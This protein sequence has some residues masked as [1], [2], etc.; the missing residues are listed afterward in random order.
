Q[1]SPSQAGEEMDPPPGAMAAAAPEDAVPLFQAG[2]QFFQKGGGL[3]PVGPGLVADG[4]LPLVVQVVVGA[5]LVQL[6]PGGGVAAALFALA[7]A[8]AGQGAVPDDP[9][10]VPVLDLLAGGHLKV[11]DGGVAALQPGQALFGQEGVAL[12]VRGP[13]LAVRARV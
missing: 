10:G 3:Q 5:D 7:V 1:V 8:V 2:G 9:G 13:E 11:H 4:V 6:L 12:T